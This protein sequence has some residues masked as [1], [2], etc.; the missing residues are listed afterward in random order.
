MGPEGFTFNIPIETYINLPDD[1]DR[2]QREVAMF[3]Y[4]REEQEWES[5]GGRVQERPDGQGLA[6]GADALHLCANTIMARNVSGKGY[7]AIRF[8]GV[9]GYSFKL[10]I[11]SYTLKE[12][13]WDSDF[14]V[15]NRFRT[16]IRGDSPNAPPDGFQYWILPQGTYN[17]SIAV[18]RHTDDSVPPEYVGHFQRT[19]T[20]DRPHWNWQIGG[21]DYEFAVP[22]GSMITGPSQLNA[23]RPA[24]MGTPTPAAGVGEVNVRLDWNANADLDLW[25]VDPCGNKIYYST[26]QRSCQGSQG[27]LDLDNRC[28]NLV[29]GLPE[30]IYWRQNPPRGTYKVYVDYY[31]K[32][33]TVGAVNYT[34]RAWVGGKAYTWRGT[35]NP[36]ASTG[37]SGDEVLVAEFTR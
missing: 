20:I 30:N 12:P 28:A 34:V 27:E 1:F 33:G 9:P 23:A 8:T 11:E 22:F 29:R 26:P 2:T 31:D 4:D 6:V 18:Y 24:C 36:P 32:C 19:I 14:E 21:P 10:C 17:L 3:D 15:N 13:G 35:I 25:V 37:A 5:V 7:G 16:I